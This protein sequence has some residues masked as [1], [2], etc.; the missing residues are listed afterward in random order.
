MKKIILI[1]SLLLF[2]SVSLAHTESKYAGD[3][4][5]IG[6]GAKALGMGGA[7]VAVAN[8]ATAVHWNPAGMSNLNKNEVNLMYCPASFETKLSNSEGQL[9]G[10]DIAQLGATY[11]YVG[12]VSKIGESM[13]FGMSYIQLKIDGIMDTRDL[14][15]DDVNTNQIRDEGERIFY[16]ENLIHMGSDSEAVMIVSFSQKLTNSMSLG[17]NLKQIS[18]SV[19][20]YSAIGMGVDIGLMYKLNTGGIGDDSGSGLSIGLVARDIGAQ[21]DWSTDE[22][23]TRTGNTDTSL[24]SVLDPATDSIAP[25][26]AGGLAYTMGMA[27]MSITVAGDVIY[28][29]Y[30]SS[31]SLDLAGGAEVV[32]AKM[33]ALRAGAKQL[34]GATQELTTL[35]FSVGCG[36]KLSSIMEVNYAL[37]GLGIGTNSNTLGGAHRISMAFRF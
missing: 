35:S 27:A 10:M 36:L 30:S 14:A 37:V 33:L 25:K 20:E 6:V 17:I 28:T 18:Q 31:S 5:N 32:V 8:D 9:G 23:T 11:N 3:F 4:L 16:D 15:F 19:L 2:L 1:T 34:A 24:N 7:F 21:L 13:K 26:I 12:L 29:P 22:K